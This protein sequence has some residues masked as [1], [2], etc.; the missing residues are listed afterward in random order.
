[1]KPDNIKSYLRIISINREKDQQWWCKDLQDQNTKHISPID[2]DKEKTEY[3]YRK[4]KY[5]GR[6]DKYEED[7]MEH[8]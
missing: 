6:K 8:S 7:Q 3:I 4:V 1:M 2:A 5:E